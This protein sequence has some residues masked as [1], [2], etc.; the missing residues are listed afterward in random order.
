MENNPSPNK[1]PKAALKAILDELKNKKIPKIINKIIL[2]Q[3]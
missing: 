1:D 2:V 3:M